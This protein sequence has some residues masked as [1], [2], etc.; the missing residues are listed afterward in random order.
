MTQH[1]RKP[2]K[3]CGEVLTLRHFYPHPSYRDG[4]ENICKKCKVAAVSENK[5]L[6]E[7]YYREQ[8]RAISARPY[9]VDQRSEYARSDRGREVHRIACRRSY[10][11]KRLMQA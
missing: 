7:D 10:R 9:Y 1:A 4:R 3:E 2:C 11:L 6:K 5:E 8:K